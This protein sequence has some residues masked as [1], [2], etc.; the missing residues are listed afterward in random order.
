MAGNLNSGRS[1]LITDVNWTE[2]EK[3]LEK[4]Y[5]RTGF[6]LSIFRSA[7]A[8]VTPRPRDMGGSWPKKI[9]PHCAMNLKVFHK[10]PYDTVNWHIVAQ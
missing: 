7:I 10:C 3:S 5:A 4:K 2:D 8:D 9:L 1:Y 6:V